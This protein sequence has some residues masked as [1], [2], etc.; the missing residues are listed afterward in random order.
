M[1]VTT[2]LLAELGKYHPIRMTVTHT[3]QLFARSHGWRHGQHEGLY[4]GCLT[5]IPK[6]VSQPR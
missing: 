3:R 2:R 5:E 1:G 6:M 4:I